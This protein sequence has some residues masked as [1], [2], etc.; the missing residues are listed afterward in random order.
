M[1]N[2]QLIREQS[3]A[4]LRGPHP[5][6]R[7]E[8]FPIP[9]RFRV[10]KAERPEPRD[11]L[12]GQAGEGFKGLSFPGLHPATGRLDERRKLGQPRLKPDQVFM[13]RGLSLLL[14]S[15]G[16][17]RE[18][19]PEPLSGPGKN[20]PGR[21]WEQGKHPKAALPLRHQVRPTRRNAL[22]SMEF[23][24]TL[25]NSLPTRKSPGVVSHKKRRTRRELCS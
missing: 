10:F 9:R 3:A 5:G 1:K 14:M 13:G 7:L 15:G 22:R 4:A 23:P 17:K 8:S 11:P 6:D 18:T 25:V 16:K 20:T 12:S 2:H 24:V 19:G 21:N